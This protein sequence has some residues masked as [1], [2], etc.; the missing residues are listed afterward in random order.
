MSIEDIEGIISKLN[1]SDDVQ[2]SLNVYGFADPYGS[3][4]C[5]GMFLGDKERIGMH[6]RYLYRIKKVDDNFYCSFACVRTVFKIYNPV[7]IR[8]LSC[9]R[10]MGYNNNF[11][12]IHGYWWLPMKAETISNMNHVINE[13]SRDVSM[14]TIEK[15]KSRI[16]NITNHTEWETREY[17][18]LKPSSEKYVNPDDDTTCSFVNLCNGVV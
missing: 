12:Q 11:C 14:Q 18:V 8:D 3:C 9:Y 16:D 2:G 4:V 15:V 13:N 10:V 5:N 7:T 1:D 6:H 17:L